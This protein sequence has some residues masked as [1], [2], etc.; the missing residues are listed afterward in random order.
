M[1]DRVKE[2]WS[3]VACVCFPSV[4]RYI[5]RTL[6]LIHFSCDISVLSYS[7]GEWWRASHRSC[8]SFLFTDL[9]NDMVQNPPEKGFAFSSPLHFKTIW[10]Y[11]DALL[12]S[13]EWAG[14]GTCVR[15]NA[16]VAS[17]RHIRIFASNFF[18][19]QRAERVNSSVFKCLHHQILLLVHLEAK[20]GKVF[21]R[22]CWIFRDSSL[23]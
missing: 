20:E 14:D 19:F 22:N 1:K 7:F 16:W 11:R 12:I 3:I 23:R 18:W 5:T 15:K 2:D 10:W 4:C 6:L 21:T 8:W 9:Q 17:W 13:Q